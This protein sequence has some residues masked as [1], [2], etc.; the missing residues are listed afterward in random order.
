MAPMPIRVGT[1]PEAQDRGWPRFLPAHIPTGRER[2][3]VVRTASRLR[4]GDVVY[5]DA[6]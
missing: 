5:E 2:A 4:L 1:L 6:S 3:P